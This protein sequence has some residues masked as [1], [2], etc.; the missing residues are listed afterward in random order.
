MFETL[1]VAEK[2]VMARS[3]TGEASKEIG[4][5]LCL[6]E[7]TV[8][9]HL[10]NIKEKVKDQTGK[11]Y[12]LAELRFHYLCETIGE[13]SEEIKKAIF[14]SALSLIVLYTYSMSFDNEE[15]RRRYRVRRREQTEYVD[16]NNNVI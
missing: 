9:T 14:A 5:K 10:K 12:K 3:T 7:N 6:T 13:H 16:V 2:R 8:N 11:T 4:D 1:S 15:S